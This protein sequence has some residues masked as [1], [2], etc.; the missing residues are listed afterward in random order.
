MKIKQ[1]TKSIILYFLVGLPSLLIAQE[2]G[3]QFERQTNWQQIIEKAKVEHKYIFIDCFATWCGPCKMMDA[4]VYPLKEVGDVYNKQFISV[5]VQMDKTSSDDVETKKWYRV[6][7]MLTRNYSINAY[8]TFLFFDS[9]G[10]LV[11]KV[12]GGF[13]AA[14]FIKLVADAQ[15]PE[16]Q[17][18]S[19][20][21]K[22]QP[23]TLDTAELKGL[24]RSFFSSDKALADKL[25]LDYLTRIPKSQYGLKD[26]E[27]LMALFQDAPQVLDIAFD[28]VN[29]TNK[30]EFAKRDNLDFILRLSRQPKIHDLAVSY[31][32]KLNYDELSRVC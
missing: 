2:K 5:K 22:F 11:H 27:N 6:A 28:F 20:L 1:L 14:H 4:E 10:K 3:I 21:K 16:K 17:Y 9:G 32:Y 12:S 18:Y 26:N 29:K 30:N 25:A 23:G 31:I 7:D 8:P 24:A 19:I 15:N 13:N